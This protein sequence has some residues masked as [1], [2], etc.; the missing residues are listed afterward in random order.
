VGVTPHQIE[1]PDP[2]LQD[3]VVLLRQLRDADVPALVEA[4]NDTEIQR[5]IP[6]P[7]PYGTHE[8]EAYLARTRRQWADGT[9]AAFAIV[10]V[11]DD[12]RLLGAINVAVFASVGNSGY[13]VA[14]WARQ[15]GVATRALRLLASWALGTVG[16]GLV[17]LEIRDENEAS[18]H[19][20]SAAGF[21]RAGRIDINDVTLEKGGLIYTRS[22]A[23]L[24]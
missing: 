11:G 8:A 5:F 14:P 9:N 12:D 24:P 15:R 13:W 23:D 2:P 17:L 4:C 3:G 21:H 16:L 20:A 7:Q 22:V 1:P 19:V 18:Q 10:D 6:V